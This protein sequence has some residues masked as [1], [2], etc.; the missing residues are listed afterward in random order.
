MVRKTTEQLLNEFELAQNDINWVSKTKV[1]L[2]DIQTIN[3]DEFLLLSQ[4]E[5]DKLYTILEGRSLN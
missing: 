1:S 5:Q 4:N 2:K 3:G